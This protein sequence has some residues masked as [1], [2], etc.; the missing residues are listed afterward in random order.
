MILL[1]LARVPKELLEV[2]DS[3]GNAM[4]AGERKKSDG[5][6]ARK[7]TRSGYTQVVG[8]SIQELTGPQEKMDAGKAHVG[9]LVRD[10]PGREH[11]AQALDYTRRGPPRTQDMQV[12]EGWHRGRQVLRQVSE[13][14]EQVLRETQRQ[15]REPRELRGEDGGEHRELPERIVEETRERLE[16][17]RDEGEDSLQPPSRVKPSLLPHFSGDIIPDIPV[18]D[19][20]RVPAVILGYDKKEAP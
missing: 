18:E 12:R 17:R 6:L 5:R 8:E 14:R 7:V 11:E 20:Q 13:R 19:V 1:G 16:G 3:G 9:Q 2:A 10:N 15:V 4:H